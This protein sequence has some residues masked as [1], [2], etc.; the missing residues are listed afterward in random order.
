MALTVA[1][2]INNM[3]NFQHL[4]QSFNYGGD[5]VRIHRSP[6]VDIDRDQISCNFDLLI[7]DQYYS[8]SPIGIRWTDLLQADQLVVLNRPPKPAQAMQMLTIAAAKDLRHYRHVPTWLATSCSKGTDAPWIFGSGFKGRCVIKHLNGAR[9]I[10]QIMFDADRVPVDTVVH[11]ARCG[12]DALLKLKERFPTISIPTA[13]GR[14][15]EEPFNLLKEDVFL[16]EVVEDVVAEYRM[17]LRPDGAHW[18][19][20][21]SREPQDGF[22][23]ACGVFDE[24]KPEND[25]WTLSGDVAHPLCR[26]E[27]EIKTMFSELGM[28]YGSVDLFTTSNGQW[29][30]FEH[31]NQ[32][33]T[34]GYSVDLM[35][36][37]HI[38]FI[39]S[40]L[41]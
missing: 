38:D 26:F 39:C 21:R 3:D 17:L 23:Q 40:K 14:T 11:A 24:F 27:S 25:H 20:N 18:V 41:S 10:G 22:E 1:L 7:T 36:K 6:A 37:Y 9:G 5:F 15:G 35:S 31:S 19:F 4:P 34:A 12:K 13:R 33:G 29:G 16:Q 30:V 32:F 2:L 28:T 8:K